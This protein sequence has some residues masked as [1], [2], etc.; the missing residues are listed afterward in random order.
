MFRKHIFTG[1]APNT[2][3]ETTKSALL[4][5]VAPW[6]W[7]SLRKGTYVGIVEDQL[8]KYFGVKNGITFDSGRTAL[9]F[10]LKGLG[11]SKGDEVIVQAYTCVVVSNA[12]RWAAA[13]PVYVDIDDNF[14]IDPHEV[15]KKITPRTK[16][17]IIQHTFGKPAQMD[18][19]M[20]IAKKHSLSV[21]EDCAH[22]FGAT[23]KGK[24]L[25][26][27]GDIGMLSFGTEKVISCVRGGAVITNDPTIASRM[28]EYSKELPHTSYTKLIQHLLHPIV[29]PIGR[30]FYGLFIGKVFLWFFHRLKITA[31][32]IY[33]RE[34]KGNQVP[35]YPTTLPNA[36]AHLLSIELEHVEELNRQ[37]KKIASIYQTCLKSMPGFNCTTWD[38]ESVYL[39]FAVRVEKNSSSLFSYAKKKRIILGNWYRTAIAP[40]DIDMSTTGYKK[41]SC[42]KAELFASQSVNLPTH[43][44]ISQ[45]DAQRICAVLTQ[46]EKSKNTSH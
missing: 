42:P 1:F 41:G 18:L 7:F 46:Y 20:D 43:R 45:Q 21:V 3:F 17:L 33:G 32:I 6:K 5:L 28:E 8:K 30:L 19:L 27:F 34:K 24:K 12:I 11:I 39:R 22:S 9:F 23:Y 29:F 14:C 4:S 10:A 38:E 35:F 44:H 25:G 37:R 13:T 36:L 16:A 15:E 26:T 2:S 31:R 40:G